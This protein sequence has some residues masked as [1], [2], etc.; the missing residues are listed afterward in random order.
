MLTTYPGV[1]WCAASGGRGEEMFWG[2]YTVD[3]CWNMCTSQHPETT[4]IEFHCE[5]GTMTGDECWCYCQDDCMCD[6]RRAR[7]RD[8][9]RN[10]SRHAR[11]GNAG[12]APGPKDQV[13]PRLG[14][15]L[16]GD[17]GADDRCGIHIPQA[18]R[19]LNCW[20]LA[21]PVREVD[22]AAALAP[23]KLCGPTPK[24]NSA[25]VGGGASPASRACFASLASSRSAVMAEAL[26]YSWTCR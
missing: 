12:V 20:R 1:G 11:A 17:I 3:D 24:T 8:G 16:G 9:G 14:H 22:P 13:E 7:A 15:R 19:R 21:K 2:A 23:S 25:A 6:A 26:S 5:D 18:D 4:S 10:A